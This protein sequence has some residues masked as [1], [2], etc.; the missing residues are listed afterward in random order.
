MAAYD[1]FLAGELVDHEL[2][3]EELD[4]AAAG[5]EGLPPVPAG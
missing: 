3:Q 2:P 4:R 1:A 5:L